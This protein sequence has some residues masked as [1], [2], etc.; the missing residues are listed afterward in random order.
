VGI[1]AVWIKGAVDEIK[2]YR[3]ATKEHRELIEKS[4]ERHRRRIERARAIKKGEYSGSHH[5]N[6]E[7]RRRY[8]RDVEDDSDRRR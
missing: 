2:E 7:E 6:A 1:A 3:E 8:L 4:E 5:L